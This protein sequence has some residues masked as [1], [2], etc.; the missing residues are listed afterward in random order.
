MGEAVPD[1]WPERPALAS[2]TVRSA[3]DT[4]RRMEALS[5]DAERDELLRAVASLRLD[6]ENVLTRSEPGERQVDLLDSAQPAFRCRHLAHRLPGA[7]QQVDRHGKG[8][9]TGAVGG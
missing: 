5:G 2:A 8:G 7:I 6:L 3:A 9:V 4:V 1:C